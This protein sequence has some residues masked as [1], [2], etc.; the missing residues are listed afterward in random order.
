V[1]SRK[2]MCR[3]FISGVIGSDPRETYLKNGHYVVSFSLAIVGHYQ[4]N[5]KDDSDC[6]LFY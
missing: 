1:P 2:D 5:N 4:V 3:V 6:Y